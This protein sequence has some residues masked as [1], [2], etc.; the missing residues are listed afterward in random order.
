MNYISGNIQSGSM[1]W[2]RELCCGYMEESS[3]TGK[4]QKSVG[5]FHDS[6]TYFDCSLKVNMW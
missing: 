6:T 3:L 2:Q 4:R 5:D 1:S